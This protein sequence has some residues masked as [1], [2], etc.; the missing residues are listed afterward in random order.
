MNTNS[1]VTVIIPCYNDGKFIVEAVNSILNQTLK[2]EK[3]IIIDDGSELETISIL[4]T[5]SQ[6]NI[7]I[8]FQENKGVCNARNVGINL[9]K[10][11]YILNL[12]ADD[13]FEA[14]FIEKAVEIF[15]NNLN[16]GVVGC[17]YR[18]FKGNV[19]DKEIIKP[20]G[21]TVK[22]FLVKN[23]G[24]SCSMFRKD[25]W[26]EVSGYDEKL[27]NGYEDW[28]FWISILSHKWEMYIIKEELFNYRI[29]EISRDQKALKDFDFELR[30]YIFLKHKPIFLDNY[31]FYALELLRIN[32]NF[33]REKSVLEKSLNY[34]IDKVLLFPLRLVNKI[35][36]KL[37]T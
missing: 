31:E 21:G 5:I 10:T 37:S 12:D 14:N 18:M 15:N 8:V 11:T 19:I 25:C 1:N 24:M 16:I 35:L 30:Q 6:E 23:N 17:F 2:A 20:L 22:N 4:K 13:Y 9:A 34:Q 32:C 26:E 7:E 3:I 29:K 33:R 36:K 27:I 28:D